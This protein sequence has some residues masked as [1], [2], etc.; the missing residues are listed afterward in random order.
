[1]YYIFFLF[2]FVNAVGENPSGMT[3]DE[4]NNIERYLKHTS[5]NIV[6]VVKAMVEE[7]GLSYDKIEW[8]T[9]GAGKK[10]E[11]TIIR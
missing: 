4:M 6:K 9:D 8:T 11:F 1:M 5:E 3:K 10:Y 7:W 2:V